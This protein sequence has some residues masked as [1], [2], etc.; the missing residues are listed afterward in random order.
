MEFA[1]TDELIEKLDKE[2][3]DY[4][5]YHQLPQWLVD[6][7]AE[8]YLDVTYIRGRIRELYPIVFS[9][10]APFMKIV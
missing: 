2:I 5:E 9:G 7:I 6:E 8:K 4:L 3:R 10:I 1:D